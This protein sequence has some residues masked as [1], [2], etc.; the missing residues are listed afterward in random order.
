MIAADGQC[1]TLA[2]MAPDT[3]EARAHET[4]T[5]AARPHQDDI[6][7]DIHEAIDGGIGGEIASAATAAT[8]RALDDLA[9][10]LIRHTEPRTE[11]RAADIAGWVRDAATQF[12]Y[13][14]IQT[15]VP[16]L[17][18]NIVR[19]QLAAAAKN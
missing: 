4:L 19:N 8:T 7:E 16:I 2:L 18:E 13:A 15:Y 14:P 6:D 9:D 11:M 10:R 1:V 12:T 5:V 17:V 3:T